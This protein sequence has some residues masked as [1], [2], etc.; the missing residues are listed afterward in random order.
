MAGRVER[1]IV[2]TS[3]AIVDLRSAAV[4]H[5]DAQNLMNRLRR[6]REDRVP[7]E[8]GSTDLD[9]ILR[10]KLRGQYG[11]NQLDRTENSDAVYRSVTRA[12]FEVEDRGSEHE[13]RVRLGLLSALPGVRVGI[14]SAVLALAGPNP[15]CVIDFRGW[16][17]IYGQEI[18]EFRF[19][20]TLCKG[21]TSPYWLVR[22]AGP[23]RR[24]IRMRL[25]ALGGIAGLVGVVALQPVLRTLFTGSNLA[26]LLP[27]HCRLDCS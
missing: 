25:A 8:L 2:I 17:A 3:N 16:R 18:R 5:P 12:V 6:L 27:L 19:Q 23:Y 7:F 9:L 11:R 26:T 24:Q 4:D 10:W 14:A 15:Y 20:T 1:P 22:S 21:A 13:A